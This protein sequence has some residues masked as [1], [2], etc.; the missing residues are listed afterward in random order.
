[1]K[2]IALNKGLLVKMDT[3]SAFYEEHYEN[4][5][6]DSHHD[7]NNSNDAKSSKNV[8]HELIGWRSV[9]YSKDKNHSFWRET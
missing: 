4:K 8:D 1:M 5:E 6:Y 2:N 9:F 3:F 7:N